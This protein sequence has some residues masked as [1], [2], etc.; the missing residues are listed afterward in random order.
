M[1]DTWHNFTGHILHGTALD[2]IDAAMDLAR[3]LGAENIQE[4]VLNAR[5]ERIRVNIDRNGVVTL[6]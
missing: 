6:A 1:T 5:G 2:D 3:E 4:T